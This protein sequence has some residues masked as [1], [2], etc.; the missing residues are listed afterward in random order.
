MDWHKIW[1]SNEVQ[2]RLLTSPVRCFILKQ[3]KE[4]YSTSVT[5]FR[6]YP[7]AVAAEGTGRHVTRF[8]FWK[9]FI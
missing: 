2:R 4:F 6:I 9:F 1:R 8:A 3:K 7:R 5:V